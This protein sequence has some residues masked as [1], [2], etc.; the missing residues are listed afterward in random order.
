MKRTIREAKKLLKLFSERKISLQWKMMLYLISLILSG[1]GISVILLIAL[2]GFGG[3]EEKIIKLLEQQLYQSS[4]EAEAE[5]EEYTGYAFQMSKRLGNELD[6]FLEKKELSLADLN[7]Q[8]ELLAEVQNILY[9]ETN[10]IIRLGRSSGVFAVLDATVNTEIPDSEYSRSSVYLRLI[11]VSSNVVLN[12]ET[13]LFRGNPEIARVYGLEL[14]NR[15]NMEFDTEVLPEW[16]AYR[17]EKVTSLE[18]YVWTYRM[19]LP[20]TWEDVMLLVVPI[21][22]RN[23]EFYGV[24]GIELNH[25]H[26]KLEYPSKESAYGAMISMIAPI[27]DSHLSVGKGMVGNTEGTWLDETE[28]LLV[29]TR[30]GYN[31]YRGQKE[32]YY[33][34]SKPIEFQM[35]GENTWVTAVLIP[36]EECDQ[37]IKKNNI[38]IMV[39][40][41]GF[42]LLMY[43]FAMY[44]SKRFVR[45][46]LKSFRDVQEG[47]EL[48]NWHSDIKELEE[49]YRYIREKDKIVSVTDLPPQ[50]EELLKQF[51]ENVK[52]LTRAEYNIFYYYM[53]GYE[54]SEI[55]MLACVSMSTIKKHNGNIYR[56]L[57]ISSNDE[58]MM[59]IDLFRRCNCLERLERQDEKRIQN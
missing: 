14:H 2:G 24:C 41:G 34:V 15:W 30:K 11:N 51:A 35:Q 50:I 40:I 21:L 16:N 4:E 18:D 49:L 44:L 28:K 46:I 27:E 37:R 3:T 17:G 7:N 31:I 59:Y 47:I 57:G 33:G 58:L 54:L 52:N 56:K 39:G 12:P 43:L 55:P 42:I 5:L 25:V 19:R 23:G 26:F 20:D 29:E 13:I 9:T 22:G 45:P 38:Y 6:D 10:T 48:E 36:R 32:D 8:S 53:E 1:I